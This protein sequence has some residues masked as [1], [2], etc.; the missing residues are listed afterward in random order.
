MQMFYECQESLMGSA[1][2]FVW[3]SNFVGFRSSALV[4]DSS[5]M[6]LTSEFWAFVLANKN[7]QERVILGNKVLSLANF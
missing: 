5:L 4:K 2:N 1:D 3:D 7:I 6:F